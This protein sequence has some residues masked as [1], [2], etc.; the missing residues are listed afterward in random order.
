MRV[1]D[2][3]HP[4]VITVAPTDTFMT[5]ASV[6]REHD[7]SAVVIDGGE[8]PVGIVT[9]RDFVRLV[10][11]GRDPAMTT[12]ESGMTA[13]LVTIDPKSDVADAAELMTA[14]HIRHLPVVDHGR[15]GGIVSIRDPV[16]RHPAMR[17][18]EEK[19][20]QNFQNRLSDAITSFAGSMVFVYVHVVWF[21]VWI[22][23]G[24]EKYPFG[25][26]TMIVSLE[27][28][29]LATFVMISQNRADA[30]RQALAD[31][32]WELVQHEERQNDEL[33]RL[34]QQILELTGAIHDLTVATE[35]SLGAPA[36]S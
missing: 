34:S 33:L 2:I 18:L 10:D 6:L 11:E 28:I 13:D 22:G 27:A 5:A 1:V 20:R 23:F 24:L 4:D 19:R 26:L 17:H 32:Q 31:H 36:E 3:M 35:T 30:K 12:C 29:F 21:G 14:H 16:M 25:L 7:V 15:L 8:G 9:E